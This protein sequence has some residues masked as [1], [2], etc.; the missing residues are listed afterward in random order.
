MKRYKG[1]ETVGIKRAR[2]QPSVLKLLGWSLIGIILTIGIAPTGRPARLADE[3]LFLPQQI[4]LPFDKERILKSIVRIKSHVYFAI[5]VYNTAQEAAAARPAAQKVFLPEG[6]TIWPIVL[7]KSFLDRL[8][9][10]SGLRLLPAFY[11]IA[12]AFENVTSFPSQ[13]FV[14][15]EG[16]ATGFFISPDGY[17]LTTYHVMREEIEAADRTEGGE[18]PLP[19]RYVSFEIPIVE[20]GQVIG[21]QP[22]KNVQLIRNV[23][24]GESKAGLDAALLKADIQS[25]AFLE[26]DLDGVIADMPVWTLGFPIRTQR[27]AKHRSSLGYADADGSLRIAQGK[28]QQLVN[29]YNFTSTADGLSGSSGGPILNQQGRVVGLVQ[30]AYPEKEANRRAVVFTGG[31]I[32]VDIRAIVKRL[33]PEGVSE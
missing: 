7:D 2:P 25:P 18:Q 22:L 23:S 1:I 6:I 16:A 12:R 24:L 27:D 5:T 26:L 15:L 8:R 10:D 31:L 17:F 19:C 33:K 3:G 11:E 32:H 13:R 20:K 21:Y 14:P 28:I 4:T 30:D 9:I 29:E